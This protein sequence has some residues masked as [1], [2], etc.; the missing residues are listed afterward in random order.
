MHKGGTKKLIWVL[1]PLL[2]VGVP[3][4]SRAVNSQ[5]RDITVAVRAKATNFDNQN[6]PAIPTLLKIASDYHLPMGIESVSRE[7]LTSP[8]EVKLKSGAVSHLL[9]AV[10]GKLSGCS[11]AV[12]DGVVD[13]YDKR[14][15][16]N[17]KNLL[18]QVV[19]MF[20]VNNETV[21]DANMRL[22][23]MFS[24]ATS[25]PSGGYAGSYIG[26][27]ELEDKRI[28]FEVSD[29]TVR[30]ILN[31]LAALHGGLVWI[32]RVPPDRLSQKPIP[33]AGLW[34][35]VP[36]GREDIRGLLDVSLK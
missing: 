3:S 10:V 15:L 30:S 32:S 35:L 31:R 19:P 9:D 29:A 20:S 7:A 21:D 27:P 22:R 13:V 8:V 25:E 33:S 11:W 17:P 36:A 18:N 28:S 23:M 1:L 4:A 34:Q 12:I 24:I 5:R 16:S 6:R 14:E 26:T 2:L